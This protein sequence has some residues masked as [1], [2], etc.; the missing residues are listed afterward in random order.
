MAMA[1]LRVGAA[2][3]SALASALCACLADAADEQVVFVS[4]NV[5]NYLLEDHF[6]GKRK[7]FGAKKPD[8]IEAC[9]RVLSNLKPD[10]LGLCEIG[11]ESDLEDLRKRLR[12]VGVKLPHVEFVHSSRDGLRHLA[13]LSRF[14]I[15]ESHSPERL[16]YRI[17]DEP[18]AFRRGI[19]DVTVEVNESYRLRCL[20]LHLKS[21][22]QS[23]EDPDEELMRRNEAALS[24][25]RIESILA[26]SPKE[27]LLVYGDFNDHP[28]STTLRVLRGSRG[29]PNY[30][31]WI[32]LK[33]DDGTEW[34]YH[35][36]RNDSHSRFDYVLV[37][38]WLSLEVDRGSSFL[39]SGADR[40]LASDHRPLAVRIV[41]K[42][43]N[44]PGE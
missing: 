14:N 26:A 28:S 38:R 31:Q 11:Q 32:N 4:W 5:R 37:S 25:Q 2:V 20:G 15:L 33:A 10:I 30:L 29:Q 9:V 24:R 43:V 17:G 7:K 41:P 12:A 8:S 42:D 3:C 36:E 44:R 21:K 16:S 19:L 40:E 34:T 1:M 23:P 22:F 27:N 18:V 6:E 13:L 39:V 35:W